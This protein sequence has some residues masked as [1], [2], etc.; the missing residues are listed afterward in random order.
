MCC[1]REL[2]SGMQDGF[3][4][5]NVELICRLKSQNFVYSHD[6]LSFFA[7]MVMSFAT[8]LTENLFVML[9]KM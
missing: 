8:L 4:V 1:Q 6:F 2:Q 7:R 9:E 3:R 5:A